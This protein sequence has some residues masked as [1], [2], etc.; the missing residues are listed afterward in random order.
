MSAEAIIATNYSFDY[1]TPAISPDPSS[2]SSYSTLVVMKAACLSN[3]W[4]FNK[5]AIIDGIKARCGPVDM[6]VN[7]SASVVTLLL[8]GGFCETYKELKKQH[9]L[10]N[11]AIFKGILSPFSHEDYEYYGHGR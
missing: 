6:T 2:D 5:K 7:S 10:G 1:S 11:S 9:N 4:E 8:T 3:Q